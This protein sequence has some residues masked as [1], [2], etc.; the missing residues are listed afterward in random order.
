[1]YFH[2]FAER[3]MAA[4][5]QY[6]GEAEFASMLTE[7]FAPEVAEI[8]KNA[9]LL[10]QEQYM[11]FLR[12]RVFR[13]T[14]LCQQEATLN[15]QVDPQRLA[16]A[17]LALSSK[18]APFEPDL[19]SAAP[20]VCETT[21]KE[22]ITATHAITKAALY[23]L[24]QTW[25]ENIPFESLL[26]SAASSLAKATATQIDAAGNRRRLLTDLMALYARKLLTALIDPPS[27]VTRPSDL[28]CTTALAR[29][30]AI[31]GDCVTNRRHEQIRLGGVSRTL[32]R[33]LDGKH[34][35]EALLDVLDQAIARGEL[36]AHIHERPVTRLERTT[37]EEVLDRTLSD[38]AVNALLVE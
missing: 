11:D 22:T 1:M 12:N 30:Q 34:D 36:K 35:R 16:V 31:A 5:L 28:P 29:T 7:T 18:F 37:L 17:Q 27:F 21:G 20:L 38:L 13:G 23:Q 14:L 6:L 24:N 26:E 10:R 25:P 15:R 4:G 32:V 33:V 8:L 19:Q 9:P 3:A 2:E